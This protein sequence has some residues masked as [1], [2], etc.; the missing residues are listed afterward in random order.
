MLVSILCCLLIPMSILVNQRSL[1]QFSSYQSQARAEYERS[2]V[3]S[4]PGDQVEIHIFRNM[5]D[6]SS[7]ASGLEPLMPS[8][9]ILSASGMSFGAG[10]A[11]EKPLDSLFGHIDLLFV[12]RFILS[13]AAIVLSFGLVS[14]EKEA[15]TLGLVLSS[16][17]PRDNF[18]LGKYFGSA[19]VLL[20]PFLFSLL[21]SMVVLQFFGG[22]SLTGSAQWIRLGA[23]ALVS[24]L[25]LNIFLSLGT[26]ISTLTSR[27]LTSMT[28]LLFLWAGLVAV[29]PQ[30]AGLLAELMFPVESSESVTFRKSLVARDLDARRAAELQQ[31]FGSPNYDELRRPVA[32]KYAAELQEATARM[33]REFENRRNVQLNIASGMAYVSPVTPL[34]LAFTTLAGTGLPQTQE[35]YTELSQ[36]RQRVNEEVFSK[37]YRDQGPGGQ[38]V[39]SIS[40]VD[41]AELPKFEL[42]E[43]PVSEMWRSISFSVVVLVLLNFVLFLAAYFRFLHYDVR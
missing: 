6:M 28:I 40:M 14:G 11:Y 19:V 42:Q 30:S 10:Q 21:L 16:P 22:G 8:S 29:I 3:G 20:V 33:D 43:I 41:R 5:A 4:T 37:G 1:D 9:V 27:A 36:F 35:F 7:L 39:L 31:H 26:L 34:T 38:T 15:G 17:V 32:L 2:L 23:I 12:V 13:L 18:L 24:V 25:Y